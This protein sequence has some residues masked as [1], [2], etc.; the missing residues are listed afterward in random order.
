M[1]AP[2]TAARILLQ[3]DDLGFAHPGHTLFHGLSFAVSPGLTLL[4]G[5]DGRGKTTLLRLV[6]GTLAPSTGH[7]R[8]AAPTVFHAEP[9]DARDDPLTGLA[10]TDAVARRFPGW[11]SALHRDLIEGF[12]LDG[13]LRKELFRLSTGTRRKLWLAAAFA[14][15]AAL[16]LLDA[17]FAA[18][19]GPARDLLCELLQDASGHPARAWLVADHALPARLSGVRLAGRIDLG[20]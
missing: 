8:R 15:G 2:D 7:L 17:P 14:S 5:G 13:H 11:D 19:D 18:L 16:T 4:C 1:D 20:D 6:A 10:W 12:E 9:V 3:A